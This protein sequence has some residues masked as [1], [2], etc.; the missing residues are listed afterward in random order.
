[1]PIAA[2]VDILLAITCVVHIARTG[3]P[4]FWVYI[5]LLVPVIGAV[6]YVAAELVP[7]LL[8]GSAGAA[9]GRADAP[10]ARSRPCLSRGQAG[11]PGLADAAHHVRAG[12][13]LRRAE[14]L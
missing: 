8:Q 5:V 10:A 2:L 6:A 14:F 13:H 1:M 4:Y 3:R 12:R 9:G 7:S 11:L